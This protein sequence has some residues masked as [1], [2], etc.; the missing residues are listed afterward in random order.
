MPYFLLPGFA[1]QVYK[2]LAEEVTLF[3]NQTFATST[4]RTY[5]THRDTYLQFCCYMNLPSV[6]A[7]TNGICLYAAF[8]A[9]SLKFSSIKQ[10]LS[11][12]GLLHKEFGLPN[13]LIANWHLSSLLT[14]IK[15]VLGNAPLQKLPITLD[16]LRGIYGLLN[17]NCS[18]DAS[19]WAIC[20]VAFFGMFRKS[21]LLS[22]SSGSFDPN[23]QFTKADFRF[24]PWGVLVR[25]RW[26]KTI[27]FREKEVFVPLPRVPGSP[28]C[29]VTAISRAFA[30]T[31]GASD[32]SQAFLWLRPSLVVQCF[33]Y[34][35]F[36]SKLRSCLGRC[37]LQGMDFGSHSFRRGGASFAFLSGLPVELI[38]ILG[39]WKS[40]AVLLYLT[41]P[42]DI[43]VQATSIISK[44]IPLT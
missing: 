38:K 4:R 28:F 11:I 41:V 44:H 40:N 8:L 18:V 30:F 37:G 34:S 3:R 6:P 25:V 24:F 26:S 15:R 33:T 32:S 27:Q 17:L 16:I 31:P 9:R 12:I 10:Y 7:T 29:P 20:L 1:S 2:E 5:S 35:L 43:R 42:L 22:T 36:M 23:R 19:F 21:H 13:P 39:D 14:G